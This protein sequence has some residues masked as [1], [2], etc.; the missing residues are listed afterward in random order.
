[1]TVLNCLLTGHDLHLTGIRRGVFE[2]H[3][4]CVKC[5]AEFYLHVAHNT[6]EYMEAKEKTRV[7]P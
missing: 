4:R 3:T 1:M 7:A 5:G 2:Y 6:K